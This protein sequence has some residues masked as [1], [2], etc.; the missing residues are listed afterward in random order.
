[1]EVYDD[2][3]RNTGGTWARAWGAADIDYTVTAPSGLVA[4]QDQ[5]V[6]T[7]RNC[8]QQLYE[9]AAARTVT[10]VTLIKSGG[11]CRR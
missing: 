6:P 8:H 7:R 9:L 1:M 3:K 4:W 11:G 10:T 5:A 2:N